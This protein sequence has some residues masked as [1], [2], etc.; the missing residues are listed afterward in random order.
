[1]A[2]GARGMVELKTKELVYEA[3]LLKLRSYNQDIAT[4]RIN[5]RPEDHIAVIDEAL[6]LANGQKIGR[7]KG[8]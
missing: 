8:D 4:G 1:M 3:A 6:W 7:E 5:Y 2:K